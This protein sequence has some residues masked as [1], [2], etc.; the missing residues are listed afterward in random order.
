MKKKSA[1]KWIT[2]N[3]LLVGIALI[4]CIISVLYFMASPKQSYTIYRVEKAQNKER[5]ETVTSFHSAISIM[6]QQ[7]DASKE[8][9]AFVEDGTGERVAIVY[10]VVNFNTKKN[11]GLNTEYYVEEENRNGYTNGCYGADG[12]Y[13]DT[14]YKE[15]IAYY[16]FQQ[17]SA[18][19]LV[20]SEEVTLLNIFDETE[21][22][23]LNHYVVKQEQI[24]HYI[25]T[26][27][28]S[29]VYAT[30]L[31]FGEAPK[32]MADGVYYS[33]NGHD[34]YRSMVDLI[35]DKQENTNANRI[36]SKAYYF[37][38][39]YMS[40]TTKCAYEASDID[41]YIEHYLGFVQTPTMFPVEWNASMLVGSGKAFIQAQEQFQVNAIGMFGLACNESDFGRSE[42]AYDKRNLFGHAAFDASPTQ[43]ATLYDTIDACIQVHADTYMRN[44]Y[45]NEND[46]RY[47]GAWFGDKAGGMNVR[48]ASDP[49]WGE[50]A[51]VNYRQFEMVMGF[52]D[53]VLPLAENIHKKEN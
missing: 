19:G 21:V 36:N 35:H 41:W 18:T 51:A 13:I 25:T 2:R 53:Q 22:A 17:A 29:D 40:Q 38:Y 16:R 32:G 1:N 26:D 45:F 20:S 11:C 5:I 39:Q 43:S 50:K 8:I 44:G 27:I 30:T 31:S 24:H 48:Y 6:K 33:Y 3:T 15:D 52:K 49:Y 42:L 10:G 14:L 28:A 46:D 9:N 47:E 37:P 4:F 7:A 34:F 23:S 12:V